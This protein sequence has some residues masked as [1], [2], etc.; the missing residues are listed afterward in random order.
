MSLA[1]EELLRRVKTRCKSCNRIFPVDYIEDEEELCPDC[2]MR[3]LALEWLVE[4][5]YCGYNYRVLPN[6]KW[7]CPRCGNRM[8][9]EQCEKEA[10]KHYE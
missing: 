7:V 4:C 5:P 9:Y 6:E 2:K 1:E 8:Q 10:L 3:P